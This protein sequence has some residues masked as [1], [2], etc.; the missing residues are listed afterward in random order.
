MFT[1]VVPSE[2]QRAVHGTAFPTGVIRVLDTAYSFGVTEAVPTTPSSGN[3]IRTLPISPAV[4][5]FFIVWVPYIT[6]AIFKTKIQKNVIQAKIQNN[7]F[8]E[9]EDLERLS[10]PIAQK[11]LSEY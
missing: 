8:T 1:V 7:F 6:T 4:L 9:V 3:T 2:V 10:L 11:D 5:G